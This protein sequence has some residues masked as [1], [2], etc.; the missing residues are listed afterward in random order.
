MQ[1]PMVALLPSIAEGIA[2]VYPVLLGNLQGQV[3][4]VEIF[5]A[6]LRWRV[7]GGAGGTWISP[8]ALLALPSQVS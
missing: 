5:A 7:L 8:V 4:P 6:P 2:L 1:M 3:L